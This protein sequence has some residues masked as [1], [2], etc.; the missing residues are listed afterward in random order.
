MTQEGGAVATVRSAVHSVL[1][2][3]G[4]TT[5]FGNPGSNELPFLAE[6]PDAFDY[7][8]GLHEGA[9]VGMAD[10]YAQAS[11]R[12]AVVNLHAASGSGNAMGA[13]TN[14]VN[15]R[16]PLVVIAGQQVRSVI[17]MEGMLAN[18]DATALP[19]PLVPF[20][21]EPACAA[22][23]PRALTQTIFEAQ[24]RRAPTYLSL[25]YDDM[26]ADAGTGAELV[27]ER[28]LRV[29]R[30]ANAAQL[31]WLNEQVTSARCPALVFGGDIDSQGHFDRAVCLAEA[32]D[33]PV[34]AAPSEFR[35]PFPNRH[36]LFRGVLPAG[37]A[38]IARALS[39]HDLVV[40]FG[41]P[42]FRYHQHEPGPYLAEGT[43]LLQITDDTGAATRS[44]FGTALVADPGAVMQVLLDR[45]GNRREPVDEAVRWLAPEPPVTSEVDGALHPEEVFAALREIQ[46]PETTYVVE[47]TATKEAFW[48]QMDLRQPASYY[49]PA[50][51]GLGFGLPATVGVQMACADRPVVGVIGDGSANYGITGLWT[52]AQRAIPA[53]FVIL[54]NGTYGA[55]RWFADLLDAPKAPG[56]EIPGIDFVRIAEGYGV[57]AVAVSSREDLHE[58]LAGRVRRRPTGPALIQVDTTMTSPG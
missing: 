26:D 51:G 25:P 19:K 23:V 17:G 1:E 30:S 42:V 55:L 5:I 57:P 7:V 52:A 35:L 50:S 33:A 21:A 2:R 34:W 16:T 41:A 27:A 12:P 22:D 28:S 43:R 4:L 3:H 58:A 32:L 39:G 8:L 15:A 45:I 53:T 20:A 48:S 13:L 6:L 14:A 56:M 36:R 44:P 37:I 38:S 40:V 11:G 31:D 49:F 10:G 46:P 54:R 29:G 24:A 9:V 18:V 47:S